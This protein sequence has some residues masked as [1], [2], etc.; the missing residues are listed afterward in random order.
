MGGER[1]GVAS[2]D[3]TARHREGDRLKVFLRSNP[4]FRLPADTDRPIIMIGPGTGLAPFRGFLQ[5]REAVGAARPQLAGV[6]ASQLHRTISCIS[7]NCRTGSR[8]G[9]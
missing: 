5:E 3:I 6:R 2:L 8:A 1:A 9:C 4:H 7:W